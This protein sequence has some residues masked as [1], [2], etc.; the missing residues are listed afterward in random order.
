[1]IHRTKIALLL[2]ALTLPGALARA[3]E[4]P[5]P[6]KNS[7]AEGL[8][9]S[10]GSSYLGVRI[11]DV[12]ADR[13]AALKLRE[14]RG[15][16]VTMVDQDAPAGKA[17]LKEHDVILDY[18]GQRVES[19]QQLRRMINETP[20]GRTASLGI[21]RDGAPMTIQVQVGDRAK[22][23]A[24]NTHQRTHEEME[25]MLPHLPEM[26]NFSFN[27]QAPPALVLGVGVESLGR[28]LAE[29]FGV[30]SGEGL[31][32]RSVEKGSAGEKAG[33]KAGD[34]I[35]RAENEQTSD[36]SELRRVLRAHQG[37]KVTLGIVRDKHEQNITVELPARKAKDHSAL[38]FTLPDQ[39]TLEEI[40]ER[41]RRL[42]PEIDKTIH[43]Q[44][45]NLQPQLKK[46]KATMQN[47]QPQMDEALGKAKAAIEKA[48]KD[49]EK[50]WQQR[51]M[52]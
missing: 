30:K 12:T 37:G 28:Q 32:V 4:Q 9:F 35:T 22:I 2:L 6:Q 10:A 24:D 39:K 31:L 1:M 38:E 16:E 49:M 27:L 17:G 46:A 48:R 40:Q 20:P 7:Y 26:Q 5:Q 29:F 18:N 21:S 52:I 36:L 47:L 51:T 42:Q 44:M 50:Y 23:A 34:V 33:L 3:A 43:E 14:E 25:M 13:L 45:R 8:F 11:Q 19:E 15:A 41:L